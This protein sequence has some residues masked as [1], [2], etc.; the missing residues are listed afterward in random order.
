MVDTGLFT[1]LG[2]GGLLWWSTGTDDALTWH[3]LDLAGLT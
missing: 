1:V 3:A 2:H